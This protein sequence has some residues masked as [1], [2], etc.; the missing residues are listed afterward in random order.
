MT[1]K[2]K[3]SIALL[4]IYVIAVIVS[5]EWLNFWLLS[6]VTLTGLLYIRQRS[7]SKLLLKERMLITIFAAIVSLLFLSFSDRYY[8]YAYIN[9]LALIIVFAVSHFVYAKNFKHTKNLALAF[10]ANF[11][12]FSVFFFFASLVIFGFGPS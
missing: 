7:N 1:S 2:T 11:L 8:I 6:I 4:I 5:L 12:F 10:L 3:K 9:W